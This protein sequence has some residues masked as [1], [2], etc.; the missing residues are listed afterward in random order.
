MYEACL[1]G[2]MPENKDLC[3]KEDL[4][5]IKRYCCNI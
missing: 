5:K 4:I 1:S 3:L 2:R